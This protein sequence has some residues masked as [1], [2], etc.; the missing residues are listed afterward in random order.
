MKT[1][2]RSILIGVCILIIG[3]S[4]RAENNQD[5]A[6]ELCV[7]KQKS[8]DLRYY[9]ENELFPLFREDDSISILEK[10]TDTLG[11]TVSYQIDSFQFSGGHVSADGRVTLTGYENQYILC[12][13]F[14]TRTIQ[15]NFGTL[16]FQRDTEDSESISYWRHELFGLKENDSP[17]AQVKSARSWQRV[18]CIKKSLNPNETFA[19]ESEDTCLNNTL[20]FWVP[21]QYADMRCSW[22]CDNGYINISNRPVHAHEMILSRRP[23]PFLTTDVKCTLRG[24]DGKEMLSSIRIRSQ[25]T[26]ASELTFDDCLSTASKSI[27]VKATNV[28]PHV[29]FRWNGKPLKSIK[30]DDFSQTVGYP[31]PG[32]D[33]FTIVL[34]TSGGCR[35]SQTREIVHRELSNNVVLQVLDSCPTTGIPFK[36]STNPQLPNMDLNWRVPNGYSVLPLDNRKDLVT[37]TK[38]SGFGQTVKVEVQDAECGG[39][40]S[41]YVSISEAYTEM[42]AKDE[43]GKILLNGGSVKA[44]STITFTAPKHSS[45]TGDKPYTWSISTMRGDFANMITGKGGAERTLTAPSAGESIS[46]TVSYESCRGKESES[47]TFYSTASGN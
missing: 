38:P 21:D 3:F 19:I 43:E 22:S 26:P 7:S 10:G 32:S 29:D 9:I 37:I 4:S 6:V 30:E 2:M 28:L 14:Y 33:D 25:Q 41:N 16:F 45:I 1:F 35:P 23:Q 31:V 46:V 40:I 11:Y 36:I 24:C 17:P 39:I 8:V 13:V 27:R 18:V 12:K 42:V 5:G 44:G 47:Y 15:F 34:T 20:K